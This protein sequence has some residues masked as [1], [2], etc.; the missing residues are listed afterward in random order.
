MTEKEL[1]RL[2]RSELLELLLIQTR[3]TERLQKKLEQAE[4]ELADRNLRIEKA[5]NI[6]QAAL[7]INGVM[8][9]AQAAAQQYLDSI[10]RMEQ[11]TARR[12]E[13]ILQQS[14][15]EAARRIREAAR[16]QDDQILI[17]EIHSP[18]DENIK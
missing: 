6:A 8:E 5:G 15:K 12:C 14:R 18:L 7:E 3:E 2:R 17:G 1:K 4:R 10:A 11:Q 9:A 13:A 16:A